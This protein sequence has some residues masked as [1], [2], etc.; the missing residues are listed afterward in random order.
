[1]SDGQ[2]LEY[3]E[4]LQRVRRDPTRLPRTP[5]RVTADMLAV[6]HEDFLRAYG[7][8]GE[9]VAAYLDDLQRMRDRIPTRYEHPSNYSL[10]SGLI[11]EIEKALRGQADTIGPRPVFGTLDSGQVNAMTLAVPGSA[12]R[13]VVFE[14][15]LFIFTLLISKIIVQLVRFRP[16]FEAADVIA[17]IDADPRIVRRFLDLVTAYAVDGHPG[18]APAYPLPSGSLAMGFALL[19]RAVN[20]FVVGHEYG[21]LIR[22]DLDHGSAARHVL[23][24]A[25]VPRR[26]RTAGRWSSR[27]MNSACGS[28]RSP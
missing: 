3:L 9:A 24:G 26:S 12:V 18:D 25:I 22:G 27:R 13:V 6:P 4:S 28:P 5:D 23:P 8:T 19:V 16:G 21:H 10:L 14:G 2:G 20:L 1:M 11:D 7:L 17:A 15:Q